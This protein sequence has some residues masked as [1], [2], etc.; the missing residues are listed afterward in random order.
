MA[1]LVIGVLAYY[2]FMN[3]FEAGARMANRKVARLEAEQIRAD[4]T[5]YNSKE[6]PTDADFKKAVSNK[7]LINKFRDL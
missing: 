2:G 3:S 1:A 7:E 6:M 5:Y 4:I